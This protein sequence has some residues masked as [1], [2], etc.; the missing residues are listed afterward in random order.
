MY[1]LF[2][3]FSCHSCHSVLFFFLPLTHGTTGPIIIWCLLTK[4]C[5]CK[6]WLFRIVKLLS[7]PSST[8]STL[9][10]KGLKVKKIKIKVFFS[11]SLLFLF[12]PKQKIWVCLDRTYFIETENW[13]HYSKIIFKYVNSTVE[14]IFN[15][16]VDKKWSL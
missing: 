9:L 5:G 14:L 2:H 8:L 15:E 7:C 16:K 12:Q 11:P 10:H 1:S 13:K 3:F 4:I 6:V